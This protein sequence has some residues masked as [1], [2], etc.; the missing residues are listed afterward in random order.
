MEDRKS[1]IKTQYLF[2]KLDNEDYAIKA[3]IVKEIVDYVDITKIPKA[4]K[5][6]RGVTN[7]RGDIIPIVDPKIRFNQEACSI[8]K[9]TSFIILNIFNEQ[10][11][12]NSHIAIMV[13]LVSEVDEIDENNILPTP[14]F[15]TKIDNKYIEN[16]IRYGCE[17]EYVTVIDPNTVIDIEELS[18]V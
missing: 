16:M 10:K 12:K 8:G 1:N 2:F 14:K 17:D 9:R 7:I 13:D 4:N 3:N 11:Q 5:A 18:K 6:I 15:G